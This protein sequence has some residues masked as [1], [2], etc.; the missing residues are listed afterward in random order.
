MDSA[1]P[2]S[3][4]VFRFPGLTHRVSIVGRT[5][6]GK[7]HGGAWLLSNAHFDKQPYYIIDYKLEELLNSIPHLKEVGTGEKITDKPGL[8]IVHPTPDDADEIEEFLRKIH[9]QTHTGLFIDEAYGI[10]RMSPAYKRILT[11][12]RSLHIPTY[13]VTQR[14]AFLNPFVLSEADFYHVFH[15]NQEA[16]EKRVEG[17]LPEKLDVMLPEYHSRWYD[18]GKNALFHLKPVPDSD[19]ILTR[20]DDRLA[21]IHNIKKPKRFFI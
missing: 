4:N 20:F 1:T 2:H 19:S 12:G 7:S 10:P 15:L 21:K 18:V 11:Q 9:A 6:S 3:K 17:Y 16:D 13:S 14:P 5:G 8:Y